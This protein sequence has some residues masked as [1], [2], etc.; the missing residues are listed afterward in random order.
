MSLGS[1]SVRAPRAARRPLTARRLKE[2]LVFLAFVAPNVILIVAFTYRPLIV[3]VYYST[4]NWT[5]GSLTATKV[6]FGNYLDFF[7][8]G[9]ASSVLLT[10]AVFT[11]C[12]APATCRSASP[13]TPRRC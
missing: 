7:S 8:D 6:G 9:E 5:L 4:L 1:E 11:V 13:P 12:G 3:N 2:W 10:T